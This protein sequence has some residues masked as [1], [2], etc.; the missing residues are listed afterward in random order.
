MEDCHQNILYEIL[1]ELIK[2]LSELPLPKARVATIYYLQWENFRK[3]QE[4]MQKN[5]V[6]NIKSKSDNKFGEEKLLN[7]NLNTHYT[8]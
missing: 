5:K 6:R 1:K 7:K 3:K 4:G 2:I 8:K